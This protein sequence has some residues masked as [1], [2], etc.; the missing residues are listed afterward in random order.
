MIRERAD[1]A[2]DAETRQAQLPP[3][4]LPGRGANRR[5]APECPIRME[6]RLSLPE[7]RVRARRR[8]CARHSQVYDA[9]CTSVRTSP[10]RF[11]CTC[12]RMTIV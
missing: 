12:L 6:C 4:M 3:C 11:P 5:I 7:Y 8:A 10:V 1:R 9:I 2:P